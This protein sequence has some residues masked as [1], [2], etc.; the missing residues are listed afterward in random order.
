MKMWEGRAYQA[1]KFYEGL[2]G[3]NEGSV[4]TEQRSRYGPNSKGLPGCGPTYS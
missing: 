3:K 2:Y 1:L 4:E